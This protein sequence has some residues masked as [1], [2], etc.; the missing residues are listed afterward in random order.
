[1]LQVAEFLEELFEAVEVPTASS[2]CYIT[3][4]AIFVDVYR[5]LQKTQNFEKRREPRITEIQ[6]SSKP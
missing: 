5:K 6:I 4:V 3:F 2:L 1:M